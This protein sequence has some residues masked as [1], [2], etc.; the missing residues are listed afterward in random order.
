[1]L[2]IFQH[3]DHNRMRVLELDDAEQEKVRIVFFLAY[4]CNSVIQ[5]RLNFSPK[6]SG[7]PFLPELANHIVT[8]QMIDVQDQQD[9]FK[10]VNTKASVTPKYDIIKGLAF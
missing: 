8:A 10:G 9:V 1:M 3:I 7:H 4:I 6:H 5:Y 2:I